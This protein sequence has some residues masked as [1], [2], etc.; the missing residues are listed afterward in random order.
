MKFLSVVPVLLSSALMSSV[1]TAADW[2]AW[3][4]PDSDGISRETDWNPGSLSPTPRIAW[5][6][7]VGTGHSSF[8]I[9]DGRLYTMGNANNID[10]VYCLNAET[11]AEIWRFDYECPSGSYA[12]PRATP[13]LDG[14]NLYS[15]SRDG[16]VH[17]LSAEDGSVIWSRNIVAEERMSIPTWGIA[18]SPVVHGDLI[19]INVGKNG[20]AL[21][22]R[23][24]RT[25]WK[26]DPQETSYA[27]PVVFE[28]GGLELVAMFSAK[29][30]N[31]VRISDG[32][33]QWSYPWAT[34]HD[35]HAA[36][37]IVHDGKMFISSGYGS[38]ATLLDITG[39]RPRPIWRVEDMRNQ[40]N[41]SVLI[42]GVIY[43]V[44]GQTGRGSVTSLDFETGRVNWSHGRGVEG[45]MAAGDKL[46]IMDNAGNLTI[47]EINPERYVEIDSAQVLTDRRARNW[48]VPVLSNG[49]IYCRNSNGD[50]VCVDVR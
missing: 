25:V 9:R 38:G 10:S 1:A 41:S 47:A 26:G 34:S 28:V 20:L 19:L 18:S 48:T 36:D 12:G 5:R 43:G 29:S 46:I 8:S 11:G 42:D 45:L 31:A 39:P 3:R 23:S 6:R 37:P 15:I 33:V 22:K 4:G 35:V 27:S 30:V 16:Q 32:S 24:G 21:D 40:F 2:P 50:I 44:D 14:D 49:R 13:V 17:C 7:N